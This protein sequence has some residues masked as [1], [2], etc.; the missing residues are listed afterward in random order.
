MAFLRERFWV[1]RLR[2]IARRLLRKCFIC[3]LIEGKPYSS[4]PFPP[5]PKFRVLIDDPY[6]AQLFVKTMPM[7][8]K[9]ERVYI[10]LFTCTSTRA[11]RLELMRDLGARSCIHGLRCFIGRR[12]APKLII[13]DKAKAF[14]AEETKRFLS[15][16]G[17][18]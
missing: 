6:A 18:S 14:K 10:F 5:L 13:S 11:I 2:Q 3:R 12:G 7:D 17:I 1:L 15:D 9:N 16:R 8:G 4:R